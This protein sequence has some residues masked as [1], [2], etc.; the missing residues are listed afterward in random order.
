[1]TI[2][3]LLHTMCAELSDADLSA[4][5]KARG[6]S[7]SETASRTSF[8][9]FYVT[10]IG[11]DNVIQT[12]SP[13]ENLTLRLLNETGEV[14]VS[15][16]DRVYGSQSG[17]FTQQYKYTFD[18]V[19]K[20]LVRRGL[21]VM[22]EVK[23][24]GDNA[25][26]ERMRFALPPEFSPYLKP[27]PTSTNPQPGQINDQIIR[28]KL[29]EL[30]GG[31]PALPKDDLPLQLKHGTIFLKEYP[32]SVANLEIWQ[33]NAWAR[34]S[35]TFK[36]S[37]PASLSPTDA[38]LKLLPQEGWANPKDIESAFNIYCFGTKI[39]STA[40]FLETGWN[41]GLLA[42]LEINGIPHYRLAPALNINS[43]GTVRT[44]SMNWADSTSRPG[45]I[46]IDLN[47]VP[48]AELETLNAL[49]KLQLDE[50]AFYATPSLTKLGRAH[51][52][53]RNSPISLWLA[54]QVE[55]FG[56]AL[57]IVNAKWGKT[58]LHENLLFAKVR[59][60]SLRIQLE[61]ELKDKIIVL[62][63][64]FIAFPIDARANVEKVLKKTGFVT[65]TIKP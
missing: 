2:P 57:G 17:T 23:M 44:S 4:I 12:L 46:K 37:I 13:E 40:K 9:N 47:Q 64:H 39:P 25:L 42:Q 19:K 52:Q 62:N 6:F 21:V 59:D 10:A 45:S 43:D 7:S 14:D 51:P 48:L 31:K 3:Q 58:I 22:A 20:N 11:L 55:A 5:R 34:L 38:A 26:L 65:K 8:A 29:M 56:E 54:E 16:F 35:N 28:K 36:P 32:F 27:I 1:M 53:Q 24:R 41:L 33:K 61:R 50:N 15:F 60:L 18:I 30:Q 63:E 49:V